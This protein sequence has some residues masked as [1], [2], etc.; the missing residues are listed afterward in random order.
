MRLFK[1]IAAATSVALM[2]APAV[3]G[4]NSAASLSVT[5]QVRAS[6]SADSASDQFGGEGAIYTVAIVAAAGA[7]GYLFLDEVVFDDEDEPDSP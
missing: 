6:S 3:A 7:I 4:A 5:S 2:A 1:S